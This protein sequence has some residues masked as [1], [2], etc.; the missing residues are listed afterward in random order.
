MGSANKVLYLEAV[1]SQQTKELSKFEPVTAPWGSWQVLDDAEA[2]KVKK[3]TVK[4][5]HR[6]SYQRHFKRE[7]HWI[8][9]SGIARITL[10]GEIHNLK[11]GESIKVPLEA[12][13]RMAN[14]SETEDLVIIEVQLGTYFGEDDIERLEDDY[15]RQ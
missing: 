10:D 4:P 12:A 5:G 2:N 11:V 15:G 14:P 6:L 13:H 8:V 3:V 9:V 7:E 1:N